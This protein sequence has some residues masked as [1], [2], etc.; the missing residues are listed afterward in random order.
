MQGLA[1]KLAGTGGLDARAVGATLVELVITIV[2]LAIAL[3]SLAMTVSFA[4]SHSAD[5][6]VQVKVVELGQAYLEEILTKRFDENSPLGGIPACTPSATVCGTIG[7]ES[8]T[9]SNF[10]DVDD[11]DGL[12]ENP[13]RDSLGIVRSGYVGYQVDI[14]VAY[15]TTAEIAAYGL[16]DQ[17]D[18]KLVRVIVSPPVGSG[19]EF[20]AY[21]GNF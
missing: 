3:V 4:S 10:N 6:M 8:E 20:S 18:A 1:S 14:S 13:P 9:R 12:S 19:I 2:I 21:K 11:Y 7:N 17:T 16:D 15:M 5:S